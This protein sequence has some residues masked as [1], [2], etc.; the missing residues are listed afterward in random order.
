MTEFDLIFSAFTIGNPWN[1]KR[2]KPSLRRNQKPFLPFKK[3]ILAL[4]KGPTPLNKFLIPPSQGG[5]GALVFFP[6]TA[7]RLLFI[8][9]FFLQ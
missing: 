3:W 4:R 8:F 7:P 2:V 5:A 9:L 1:K 6:P